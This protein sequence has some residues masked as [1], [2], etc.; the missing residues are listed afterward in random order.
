MNAKQLNGILARA[1]YGMVIVA[2]VFS[3]TGNV[4]AQDGY[5]SIGYHD[6]DEGSVPSWN[7]NV[8]GWAMDSN[9]P[10]ENV[11]IRIWVDDFQI[12]DDFI[13]SNYRQDLEEAWDNG[14]GGCPG[15]TCAFEV[16]IWDYVAHDVELD[17]L[18]EA[19]ELQNGEWY[20]LY[21][22]P[23]SLICETPPPH[24]EAFAWF[25]RIQLFDWPADTTVE[26]SI[27]NP[28]LEVTGVTVDSQ[29]FA[30]FY[31]EVDLQPES[32]ITAT[33]GDITKVLTV[34]T[35]SG[36]VENE[37]EGIVS[38]TATP[39]RT[40]HMRTDG[41]HFQ[42][43]I[44]Q[45]ID[46]TSEDG[47]WSVTIGDYTPWAW[48]TR[49]EMWEGDDDGDVTYAIWHVQ[50]PVV[51]IWLAQNEIRA[52][53]WPRDTD[54][55][56][57]VNDEYLGTAPTQPVNWYEGTWAV[58]NAWD[59]DLQ[60]EPGMD[61][62]VSG[63]EIEKT[64]TIQDIRI[65]N[66]DI[67]NDVVYGYAPVDADLELGSW[68]DSPV[69]RFFNNG[70][71]T[72]W[73]IDYKVPS[74]NGVTVDLDPDDE[75]RLFMRDEEKDA[76]VWQSF[77]RNP[78]F[79]VFPEWEWFDGL[80]WPD[81]VTVSISVE[82]KD[83]CSFTRES[84]G[85]FFNGNFPEGCNIE[86]GDM[87]T[88]DDGTTNRWHE[89]RNLYVTNVDVDANTVGGKAEV[90][91]GTIVYVWP[92]NVE[93][94]PLEAYVDGSGEWQVNF[95][96]AYTIQGDSE[97]R[98]E[99]RD[100][101]GN[102]TASDWHVTHPHFTVFPEWEWF[103]GLDWPNESTITITV[104]DKNG[105]DKPECTTT[106]ESWN[107]FFNGNFGEGGEGCDVEF[108]DE[109]TFTFGD[110]IRR[111]TVQELAVTSVDVDAN[112]VAGTSNPNMVDTVYVW[113]HCCGE[114][115]VQTPTSSGVWLAEFPEEFDLEPGMDGRAEIRDEEYGNATAVDWHA[116]KP[117][118]IAFPE[119]EAVE[120]WEWPDGKEV[121]LTIDNASGFEMKGTA[122]VTDWGDPRTYVRFEF[123]GEDGYDLQIG[124]TVTLT[125]EDGTIR[126]HIVQNLSVT[127]VN[128]DADTISGTADSSVAVTLWPHGYDQIATVQTTT[129]EDDTWLADFTEVGFNLVPGIGGRSTV[130]GPSGNWT[131]VDWNVPM[132]GWQQINDSGFGNFSNNG[133]TALETFHGQLYAGAS[134]WDEGGEVWRLGPDGLWEPVS[135]IGFGGGAD[136]PAIIDMSVFQG[137]LY[138]GT[139][140]NYE[141]LG[142]VWRSTNGTNWQPV[143]TDGFDDSDNIA[144]TN[145]VTYK[146]MLY[147]GTGTANGSAQ[148]W[149][150]PTGNNGSWTQVAPDDS[151]PAGNV[152]GFAVYKGILY[153][154]IEP[155][156]GSGIPIQIWRSG[157]GS[158]W[159]TVTDDGFGDVRNKST[160][161]FAQFGGYLYLGIRN[162]ETGAQ[163]W[164]TTDGMQWDQV[165]GDGFGDLNNIKIESLF[166]YN[167][168]FYAVT[169][170][171]AGLQ[172]WCSSN[173]M[174]WEWV[175]A[176]GFGDSGNFS[177]LWN[178]A[179]AVYQGQIVIGT[180]NNYEGGEV[181]MFTP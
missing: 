54:L 175:A 116:P 4:Y 66:I 111:H 125:G 143:T 32:V 65:T 93:I 146:G 67:D 19:Q 45:D 23:K 46:V 153:A 99:I 122:H 24:I 71:D 173:G 113:P 85:N 9:S 31:P 33:N 148:I 112:T 115:E 133:A 86:A 98:S 105:T 76:T 38:G 128:A 110:T 149:R 152:T 16:N 157:N 1:M 129:G 49:G 36:V 70:S 91:E 61:V 164:R 25:D 48:F 22:T 57:Y 68:E 177:T 127:D 6:Y 174:N 172:V 156:D 134:N 95:G 103:D 30:E 102:A 17:V 139:G 147:A 12:M 119:Y 41:D 35:L 181:W 163:L 96:D 84:W 94:D 81:G 44:E 59:Y 58:F 20:P 132:D 104:A 179:T 141:T 74:L 142:Q 7:C 8:G 52:F 130:S 121:T 69:Y 180:W 150:S 13:T 154:A 165:V 10:G 168:L 28:Y 92:H 178:S 106:K 56:F 37:E 101:M 18:V 80:D 83:E 51:E 89:V 79:T 97:G 108:G 114:Y 169:Y 171:W 123:G 118:L 72:N 87:V 160:G 166:V 117:W 159:A 50:Q 62:T 21:S 167:D 27:S 144:V 42:L 15:G 14:T 34:S 138:V 82:G 107:Y 73:A 5:F 120:G 2:M 176:N 162:D 135:E 161:G 77:A 90:K 53:G 140:L 131:A 75:I 158:D 40:F 11:N 151:G 170:N 100:E 43:P 155:R 29:G 3:V 137:Q 109:V 88:F 145:F 78:H 39:D 124:D 136:N 126:S 64:T 60:L 63:G 55:E 26:V 47:S